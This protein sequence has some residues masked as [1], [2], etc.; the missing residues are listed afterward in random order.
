MRHA[1]PALLLLAAAPAFA[2]RSDFS[3]EYFSI[4]GDTSRELSA[5]IDAKGPVGDN[6]LRSDGYT[7]W[8]IN[9][10]FDMQ[11]DATGCT[12]SRIVVD[13][14]VR[15]T[16]PRWQPPRSA[17]PALVTRW[18]RYLS[19]LRIHEDGHRFRAEAAA[20]DVRRA[21]QRE[22]GAADCRTLEN[23]L[24]ARANALLDELRTRQDAYDRETQSGRKQGVRRP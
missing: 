22:R 15:M 13:L 10:R 8:F 2:D 11:S 21:L 7:R 17:D 18:N 16:L 19:A 5:E 20:G 6:G 9:W 12:A 23:R 24:N 3:I 1:W 4:E 14:A